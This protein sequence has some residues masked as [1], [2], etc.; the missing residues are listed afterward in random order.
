ML[1]S[2]ATRL[3][4]VFPDASG[5]PVLPAVAVL[6]EVTGEMRVPESSIHLLTCIPMKTPVYLLLLL[7]IILCLITQLLPIAKYAFET[8]QY[9]VDLIFQMPR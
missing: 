5:T 1:S 7:L 3:V 2:H 9:F 4:R 6:W 8:N